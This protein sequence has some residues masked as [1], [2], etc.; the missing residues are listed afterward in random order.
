MVESWAEWIY[1]R[2]NGISRVMQYLQEKLLI[3]LA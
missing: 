1:I 3:N 2:L